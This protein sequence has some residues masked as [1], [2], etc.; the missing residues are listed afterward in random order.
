MRARHL[1]DDQQSETSIKRAQQLLLSAIKLSPE[2]AQAHAA[3]AESSIFE[4]WRSDTIELLEE[5]QEACNTAIKY[6]PDNS[7]VNATLSHLYR[8]TGRIPESIQLCED[9]LSTHKDNIYAL[10][11][12]AS[13]YISACKQSLQEIPDAD[14]KALFFSEKSVEIEP[15][16]WK[17][18]LDLGNNRFL[19]GNPLE[20]LSAYEKSALLN[21][22][23]LTYINI[24]VI[25]MCQNQLSKSFQFFYKAQKLFPESY[26]S[27]ENLGKVYFMTGNFIK[28]IDY[29]EKALDTF[30]EKQKASI[31]EMWGALADAYRLAGNQQKAIEAYSNAIN[32]IERDNLQGYYDQASKV[33]H[34]FYYYIISLF[35]PEQYPVEYLQQITD[36]PEDFIEQELSPGAYAKL[37]YIFFLQGDYSQSKRAIL[38]A[39]NICPVFYQHPD[40]KPALKTLGLASP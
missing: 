32:I 25:S 33:Y 12:L 22:K 23:E 18:Y 7:Y 2:F 35:Q 39:T 8:V 31:H 13:A 4:S 10:S 27:Y 5:A 14:R 11:G 34:Y 3:L 24:G 1:L 21:P 29:K 36:R 17:H 40:I 37:A 6:A 16:Y 9:I 20:A 26:L 28:S 38:K 15:D 19:T 30:P